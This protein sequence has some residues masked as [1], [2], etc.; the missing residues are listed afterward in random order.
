MYEYKFICKWRYSLQVFNGVRNL[1]DAVT[2]VSEPSFEASTSTPEFGFSEFT[3]RRSVARENPASESVPSSS[4]KPAE[5]T[6]TSAATEKITTPKNIQFSTEGTTQ[7]STKPSTQ[8]ATDLSTKTTT[9]E[10]ISFRSGISESVP[11]REYV[12]KKPTTTTYAPPNYPESFD[13]DPIENEIEPV[14][15]IVRT[16]VD[17]EI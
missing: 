8:S 12:T 16:V 4:V 7:P 13:M 11:I 9:E 2:G 5:A 14:R 17:I 10:S 6:T 15:D 1:T 3:T